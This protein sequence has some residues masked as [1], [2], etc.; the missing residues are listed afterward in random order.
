M[1]KTYFMLFV[2]VATLGLVGCDNGEPK[3]AP[4]PAPESKTNTTID[5]VTSTLS[6]TATKAAKS[7]MEPMTL[8]IR[9]TKWQM[10]TQMT[11]RT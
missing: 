10:T 2:V 7:A 11:R 9:W 5:T 8:L 6:E 4:A 1:K 3:P